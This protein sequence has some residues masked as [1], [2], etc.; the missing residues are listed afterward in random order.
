MHTRPFSFLRAPHQT[1]PKNAGG[2]A[3]RRQ[4]GR[5]LIRFNTSEAADF[6]RHKVFATQSSLGSA[7]VSDDFDKPGDVPQAVVNR[8]ENGNPAGLVFHSDALP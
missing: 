6:E 8:S 3:A 7:D 5:V 4:F 1:A 2:N